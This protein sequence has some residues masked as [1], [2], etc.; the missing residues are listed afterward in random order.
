M[1]MFLRKDLKA[2]NN[3]H[4][5]IYNLIYFYSYRPIGVVG[6][7]FANGQGGRNP[8]PGRVIQKRYLMLLCL[9]TSIVSVD[10]M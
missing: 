5:H 4:Q 9:F 6:R 8:F 1:E 7:V 3:T 10:V 2:T